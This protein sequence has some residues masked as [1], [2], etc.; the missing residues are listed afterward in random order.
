MND[1]EDRIAKG[2]LREANQELG[3]NPVNMG[4]V[5]ELLANYRSLVDAAAERQA[6]LKPELTSID[7]RFAEVSEEM[8]TNLAVSL[9]K[10]TEALTKADSAMQ[11]ATRVHSQTEQSTK[12][13][14]TTQDEQA[15]TLDG[16]AE[17]LD[18]LS[19][20]VTKLENE[21]KG[22]LLP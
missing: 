12:N 6:K 20:R 17:A 22:G 16:Q 3:K 14:T 11:A 19:A 9:K 2:L 4:R 7:E 1:F 13:L 8:A 10:A 5:T 21:E 15:E 18:A